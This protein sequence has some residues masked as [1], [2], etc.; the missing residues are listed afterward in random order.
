MV[1]LKVTVE[2]IYKVLEESLP[3]FSRTNYPDG[4]TEDQFYRALADIYNTLGSKLYAINATDN[5]YDITETDMMINTLEQYNFEPSFGKNYIVGAVATKETEIPTSDFLGKEFTLTYT[6]N[7]AEVVDEL[8]CVDANY[9]FNNYLLSLKSKVYKEI[10]DLSGKTLK[11]KDTSLILSNLYLTGIKESG[12]G[13][14]SADMM[15]FR[16]LNKNYN[17]RIGT[18]IAYFQSAFQKV[19]NIS[20]RVNQVDQTLEYSVQFLND[21]V[22]DS[23]CS[24]LIQELSGSTLYQEDG[25]VSKSRIIKLKDGSD[26]EFL[27]SVFADV[28]FGITIKYKDSSIK[29]NEE[30][31]FRLRE[32]LLRRNF[33]TG[34][35]ILARDLVQELLALEKPFNWVLDIEFSYNQNTG[36][37]VL[38]YS[39]KSSYSLLSN[40]INILQEI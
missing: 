33:N 27:Y 37:S 3:D 2:D 19:I 39:E 13:F 30:E 10:N 26:Y 35:D 1:G 6:E 25:L 23:E 21:D 8:V 24:Y 7:N 40:G 17:Y 15:R 28:P 22:T 12:A 18:I 34:E 9:V 14:E 29:D 4:S 36:L 16:F 5:V 38:V 11:I 32:Y 20:S 31:Q